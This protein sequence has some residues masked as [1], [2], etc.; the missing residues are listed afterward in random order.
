KA[1]W[2]NRARIFLDVLAAERRFNMVYYGDRW[3]TFT[4]AR[5]LSGRLAIDRRWIENGVHHRQVFRVDPARNWIAA[6][7]MAHSSDPLLRDFDPRNRPWYAPAQV[8]RPIWTDPYLFTEGR[9]G[10][11]AALA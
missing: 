3:G 7:G 8:A 4:A 1:S 10:I 5:R 9:A 2:R 6:P 11:T